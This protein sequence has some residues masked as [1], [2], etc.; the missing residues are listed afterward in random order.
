[1]QIN[2]R[3]ARGRNEPIT[4][5]ST[6]HLR[7]NQKKKSDKCSYISAVIRF[8]SLVCYLEK[9]KTK[10]LCFCWQQSS[11]SLRNLKMLPVVKQGWSTSL[12]VTALMQFPSRQPLSISTVSRSQPLWHLRKAGKLHAR[13]RNEVAHKQRDSWLLWLHGRTVEELG[14]DPTSPDFL[15]H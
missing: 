4:H 11:K 6:L 13:C 1:M 9:K 10:Q 7:L 14:L 3:K 12:W 5:P 8:Y 2:F 15:Q